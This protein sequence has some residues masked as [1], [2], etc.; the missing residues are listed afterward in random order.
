MAED[1]LVT[2][3]EAARR[4]GLNKSTVSRQLPRLGIAPDARGLFSFAALVAARDGGLNGLKAPGA[5]GGI[6]PA[7]PLAPSPGSQLTLAHAKAAETTANAQIKQ[8]QLAERLKQVVDRA[9]VETAAKDA[10]TGLRLLLQQRNRDLAERVAALTDI[11]AI[12][13]LLDD[14]DR[15][16]LAELQAK[17]QALS[18]EADDAAAA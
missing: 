12:E 16:L 11:D 6:T 18:T 14:A 1:D 3:T 10:G 15:K 5:A 13:L 8:L 4:L 9:G 17:L 7:L 2:V